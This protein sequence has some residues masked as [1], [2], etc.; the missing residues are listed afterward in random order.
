MASKRRKTTKLSS[1]IWRNAKAIDKAIAQIKAMYPN[2]DTSSDG[3][4]ASSQHHKQN[5]NSDH[6]PRNGVVLAVD[7]THDPSHGFNSY[8]FA[9]L[10]IAKQD[11][12]L[13][14]VISNS[15]I[16][17]NA[18][19]VKSNPKLGPNGPWTWAKYNGP[20]PH[21]KHV[22]MSMVRDSTLY[23]EDHDWDFGDKADD[24]PSVPPVKSHSMLKK[25]DK[26]ADVIELQHQLNYWGFDLRT[27]GDFGNVTLKAVKTFQKDHGILSD[28]VV[29]QY[30]WDKLLNSS[31]APEPKHDTP[32]TVALPFDV[33]KVC[34]IAKLHPIAKFYWPKRGVAP[35]GYTAGVACSFAHAIM[36][37]RNNYEPVVEMSKARSD[38]KLD[39]LNHYK[40]T[41]D[42]LSLDNSKDGEDTL[43]HLFV[44]LMGLGMRES[45][46]QY[47]EG[48]D[49][50]A[51]NFSSDTAEAGTWQTS[52]DIHKTA[53]LFDQLFADYKRAG[54]VLLDVYKEGVSKPISKNWGSGDG[55]DFQKLTKNCPDF[56]AE[57]AA[58]GLRF[59][60]SHWGPIN[61]REA[62]VSPIA[63]DML[64][65]VLDSLTP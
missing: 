56:A 11:P 21:D 5:P 55:Y 46:G 25:G 49:A 40:S 48:R 31:I 45:S 19:F 30:T 13:R 62:T 1:S 20:N 22:H 39:A 35:I 4:K 12:R 2:R 15:R 61:R 58:Y 10:L 60:C 65:K 28:G 34:T 53:P 16:A 29:G 64:K 14:Y 42:V 8:K 59:T 44:L 37:L 52:W 43:R 38:R 27:D 47:S 26:G 32:P 17:G 3:T 23:D 6:E 18:E 63:D 41:F 51:S 33:A 24:D 57:T 36:K 54:N 50:S 9:D 7:F